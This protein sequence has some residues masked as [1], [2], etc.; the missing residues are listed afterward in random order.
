MP[1]LDDP[2]LKRVKAGNPLPINDPANAGIAAE[3]DRA[4]LGNR[5]GFG[6][7]QYQTG[8]AIVPQ[9]SPEDLT[10]LA[11][12]RRRDILANAAERGFDPDAPALA[13][14][15]GRKLALMAEQRNLAEIQHQD[16]LT[17]ATDIHASYQ[18]NRDIESA[19]SH[20]DFLKGLPA[21]N[22]LPIEARKEAFAQHVLNNEGIMDTREGRDFVRTHATSI[23]DAYARSQKIGAAR[24]K[25]YAQSWQQ[26]HKEGTIEA[27][28]LGVDLQFNDQGFPSIEATKKY[29]FDT[30][31]EANGLTPADILDSSKW[32][33][34]KEGK[35]GSEQTL[36][37]FKKDDG[38]FV[39]IPEA[40][41]GE[42][43]KMARQF[44][45][46][47]Q[48]VPQGTNSQQPERVTVEKDGKRFTLPKSQLDTAS[49]QG[50]TLVQ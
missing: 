30:K 46:K 2:L 19:N 31:I 40:Q 32:G 41:L 3:M 38:E 14:E 37:Y 43:Q 11:I 35:K 7:L 22:K 47:E 17:R 33:T 49:K 50:F 5:F 16:A 26:A 6:S 42:Y 9:R 23:D 34:K 8:S 39:T 1:L 18:K 21:I 36:R 48:N 13:L 10:N 44:Y 27:R 29:A 12:Q 45:G 25:N 4:D 28:K 15:P 20:T 24:D